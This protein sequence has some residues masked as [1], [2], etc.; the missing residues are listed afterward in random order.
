[1][2]ASNLLNNNHL[3]WP[4]DENAYNSQNYNII[5]T[6]ILFPKNILLCAFSD[7][8]NVMEVIMEKIGR[9]LKMR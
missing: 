9:E 7:I 5:F 2:S 8:E 3:S 1:M 6:F 4:E